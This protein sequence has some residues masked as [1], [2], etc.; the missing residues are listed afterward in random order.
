MSDRDVFVPCA[1]NGAGKIELEVPLILNASAALTRALVHT[2][3]PDCVDTFNTRKLRLF[4]YPLH[5]PI[6]FMYF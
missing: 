4:P 1:G 6:R 5:A 3:D 2:T